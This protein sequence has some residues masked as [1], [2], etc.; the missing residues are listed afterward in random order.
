MMFA[1]VIII[2]IFPKKYMGYKIPIDMDIKTTGW[3]FFAYP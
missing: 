3:W 1:H 2:I